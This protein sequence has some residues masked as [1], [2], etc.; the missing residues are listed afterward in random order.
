[1]KESPNP[2]EQDGDL[3]MVEQAPSEKNPEILHIDADPDNV[4]WLQKMRVQDFYDDE[5]EL[6]EEQDDAEG[7]PVMKYDYDPQKHGP[8][9]KGPR[10]GQYF[11]PTPG[12]KV[13]VGTVRD[14]TPKE[15][16]SDYGVNYEEA[17]GQRVSGRF[18]RR[19]A[20]RQEDYERRIKEGQLHESLA[21]MP[22]G[23]KFAP[24]GKVP[25][26]FAKPIVDK[27]NSLDKKS[28]DNIKYKLGIDDWSK[29]SA[30]EVKR[31][32]KQTDTET[33]APKDF[34]FEAPKY[35]EGVPE[36]VKNDVN[37]IA[38][39][40]ENPDMNNALMQK[41]TTEGIEVD[42]NNKYPVSFVPATGKIKIHPDLLK[43]PPEKIRDNIASAMGRLFLS[44]M[45]RKADLTNES[46]GGYDS[47]VGGWIDER[48]YPLL[49]E[50]GDRQLYAG[51]F[52]IREEEKRDFNTY[53]AD[54]FQ[55]VVTG[56]GA[57]WKD[58]RAVKTMQALLRRATPVYKL[59]PYHPPGS[60]EQYGFKPAKL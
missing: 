43:E 35:G 31:V 11:E 5:S 44:Q 25:E 30:N 50:L 18:S 51:H 20:A 58:E 42:P 53:F 49:H 1:M 39:Q 15:R 14:T 48:M 38:N 6:D 36:N 2:D 57:E 56:R 4:N 33:S 52:F 23:Y 47:H 3:A 55:Y 21:L 41:L 46:P 27:L 59:T 9:K 19:P 13:Y 17:R 34:R 37:F 24:L 45:S 12:V 29:T 26:A 28:Q 22:R 8:L 60:A 10:G 40:I 32:L 7:V 16:W 54:L